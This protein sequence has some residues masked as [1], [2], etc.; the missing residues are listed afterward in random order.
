MMLA[1]VGS[2]VSDK[3]SHK[4][5]EV[6]TTAHMFETAFSFLYAFLM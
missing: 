6:L 5:T 3:R 4:I 1:L 2:K